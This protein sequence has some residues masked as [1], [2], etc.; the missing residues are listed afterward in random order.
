[1]KIDNCAK[2]QCDKTLFKLDEVNESSF[3]QKQQ[4]A[5]FHIATVPTAFCQGTCPTCILMLASS[6]LRNTRWNLQ[7]SLLLLTLA[8]GI[9]S[10]RLHRR[11]CHLCL[12]THPLLCW[13]LPPQEGPQHRVLTACRGSPPPATDAC[14][15]AA[16]SSRIGVYTGHAI[17]AKHPYTSRSLPYTTPD[18]QYSCEAVLHPSHSFPFTFTAPKLTCRTLEF[19]KQLTQTQSSQGSDRHAPARNP[20]LPE[21]RCPDQPPETI[22][23]EETTFPSCATLL[24]QLEGSCRETPEEKFA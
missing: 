7:S 9:S 17:Q 3:Q 16:P 13:N 4:Q 12:G 21:F 14:R 22:A 15:S 20:S 5:P 18:P 1:M 2:F 23:I 8:N 11:S 10:P 6:V 24:S 19:E